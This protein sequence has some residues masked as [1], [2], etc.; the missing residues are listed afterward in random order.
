MAGTLSLFD[1]A[2]RESSIESI[3]YTSDSFAA[4][5]PEPNQQIHVTEDTYNDSSTRSARDASSADVVRASAWD[6]TNAFKMRVYAAAK[7]G[8]E[9][10]IWQL[11]LDRKPRYRVSAILPNMNF[12]GCVAGLP[13]SSTGT[14][15]PRLLAGDSSNL[16]FPVQWYVNVRD[17]AK[18]HIAALFDPLANGRRVFAFAE[19]FNWNDILAIL[20]RLRPQ[21]TIMDDMPDLGRDL[22]IVSNGYARS[23][24]EKRYGH[25]WTSL[26]ETVRQNLE[27]L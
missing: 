26:E 22:S 7:A 14:C 8:A 25:G 12:G 3:V 13:P 24:L 18:L 17:C 21:M 2:T 10:A 15:V 5:L 1:A 16:L 20:R 4:L 23:L 27:G 19:P 6:S 11:V 9:K